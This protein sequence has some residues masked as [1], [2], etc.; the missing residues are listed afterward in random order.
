[1]SEQVR[2][3]NLSEHPALATFP[4]LSEEQLAVLTMSIGEH[5]VLKPLVCVRDPSGADKGFVIDGRNR[6]QGAKNNIFSSVPVEWAPEGTDPIVYAIESAI[7]GRNLTRS[8]VV[9]LLLEQHPDL[10]EER[11]AREHGGLKHRKNANV[12][13]CDFVTAEDGKGSFLRIAERYNVP[14]EYFSDLVKIQETLAS[15][16]EGWERVRMAI[17]NG[18]GS[19]PAMV[20]GAGGAVATKGKNRADP[21]YDRLAVTATKTLENVFKAWGKFKFLTPRQLAMTENNLAEMFGAMPD[22][23]RQ[24]SA[25]SIVETWPEHEKKMLA[26]MLKGGDR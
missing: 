26:K 9:L 5:G 21:R 15:D 7:S 22:S 2:L 13:R 25:R 17:L 24:I 3:E 18:E 4:L 1:M 14:R 10:A 20:R 6:L 12:S 11:R 8:G 23:V 16:P 19:I